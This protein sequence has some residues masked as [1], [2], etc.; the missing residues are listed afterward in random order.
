MRLRNLFM[1]LLLCMT[2]GLF[3]V[4]CSDGDTGP[5][6]P[7][8]PAGPAGPAG[9]AGKDGE[10]F[11]EPEPANEEGC[12]EFVERIS[13]T[14]GGGP[15][16]ICGNSYPNIINGGPGEDTIFGRAG[17]DRLNGDDG[18]DTL[19]GQE[20]GDTL[21]GGPGND[22][23]E[24]GA[25]KDDLAGEAGS[26]VM[27]GGAGDDTFWSIGAADGSD[28]FDGGA[29]AD[30]IDFSMM[31][32]NGVTVENCTDNTETGITISLAQGYTDFSTEFDT[33][34]DIENVTG[35]C[36]V[37]TITGD[38]GNNV[39]DG[40]GGTDT[41]AGGKGD[42]T[43]VNPTVDSE[44]AGAEKENEG[45]DTISY[46]G[47]AAAGT[48]LTIPVNIENYVGSNAVD[49]IIGNAHDNEITGGKEADTIDISSGGK[50]TIIFNREDGTVV[51]TGFTVDDKNVNTDDAEVDK[52]I[53]RGYPAADRKVMAGKFTISNA[54]ISFGGTLIITL[55]DAAVRDDVLIFE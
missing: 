19:H 35:T 10:D 20:D 41:L 1:I 30:E 7:P 45:T 48:V 18:D 26:D 9:D 15:D 44:V 47:Q 3:A 12:D 14:A 54:E 24:G 2:V 32:L 37:D 5:Q 31:D 22:T 40:G 27:N 50:D 21:R 38:D 8:G 46:A 43:Y 11:T 28:V 29:G 34:K 49:A 53:I 17:D 25:G 55:T 13:F 6:G 39:L 23:L 4:S 16:V 36:G 33:Y 52:L 42:D 51:V